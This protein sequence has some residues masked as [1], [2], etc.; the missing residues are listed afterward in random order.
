MLRAAQTTISQ[1]QLSR[2]PCSKCGTR[3][4]LARIEPSDEQDHD[5]R[6]FEC[7]ACG[8]TDVV[9]IKIK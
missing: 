9:K 6:T 8:N 5:L 1:V 4:Q 3:T 2:P 7:L